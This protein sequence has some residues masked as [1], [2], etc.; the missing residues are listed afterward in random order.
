M[1]APF[2][3]C[4]VLALAASAAAAALAPSEKTQTVTGTIVTVQPSERLFALDLPD[5]TRAEFRWNSETKINGVL[6]SGARVTVRYAVG[7][8]GKNLA[9]QVT[10]AHT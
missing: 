8:D 9:L 5:G 2:F 6:S 4:I 3:C 7:D 1:R 10:V